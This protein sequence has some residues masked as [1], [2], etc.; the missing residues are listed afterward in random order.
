M[1]TFTRTLRPVPQLEVD[2]VESSCRGVAGA[3]RYEAAMATG[4]PDF[5]M[6]ADVPDG[7]LR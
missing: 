5:L 3:F 4:G 7:A 1:L 6:T 2:S